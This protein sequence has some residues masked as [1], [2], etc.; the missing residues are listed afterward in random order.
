MEDAFQARSLFSTGC[1]P[2]DGQYLTAAATFR[3]E[4]LSMAPA[5]DRLSELRRDRVL[6]FVKWVPD[7]VCVSECAVPARGLDLSCASLVNTTAIRYL[8]YDL[9]R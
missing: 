1:D 3:G 7:P 2:R 4:S 9:R 6:N 8:F 5:F